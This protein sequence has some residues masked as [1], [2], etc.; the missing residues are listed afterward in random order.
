M[1]LFNENI[2]DLDLVLLDII[3]PKLSGKAVAEIIKASRPKLPI[4]FTSGY[5]E[6]EIHQDFMLQSDLHLVKKPYT[7]DILLSAIRELLDETK[8]P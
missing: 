5:S 2:D 7:K 3:I 1:T 4:L 6:N 8:K